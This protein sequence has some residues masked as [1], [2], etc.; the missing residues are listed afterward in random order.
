MHLVFLTLSE[1]VNVD[2]YLKYLTS[3]WS[4]L[5]LRVSGT[6]LLLGCRSGTMDVRLV[7]L[8]LLLLWMKMWVM[9]M[10][11]MLSTVRVFLCHRHHQ[12]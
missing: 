10:M 3:F 8:L 6:V 9:M 7:K 12:Y 1:V 5:L 11:M 4:D 2:K